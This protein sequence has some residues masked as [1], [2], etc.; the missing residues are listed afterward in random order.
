MFVFWIQSYYS[1]SKVSYYGSKVSYSGS[2]AFSP[3]PKLLFRIQIYYSR[4]KVSYCG[5][6]LFTPDPKF[7]TVDPKL[8]L[9]IQSFYSGSKVI[10]PN[11][12]FFLQIKG[13]Y[14]GSKDPI[15][16]NIAILKIWTCACSSPFNMA[17]AQGGGV[18]DVS[19]PSIWS[20]NWFDAHPNK[21][22]K[23]FVAIF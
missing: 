2:K 17:G 5:S 11:P 15:Q 8:F 16:Y 22:L 23:Y 13:F 3:D 1:R 6:K 18:G 12:K 10:T 19:F 20:L 21:W 4:F 7:L 9:R 14:F